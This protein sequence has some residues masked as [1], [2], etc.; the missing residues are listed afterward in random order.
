[1]KSFRFA[2]A[3]RGRLAAALVT[4]IM[5]PMAALA[6]TAA[7]APAA[8]APAATAPAAATAPG[9][10]TAWVKICNVDA[11]KNQICNI[12]QVLLSK[13]GSVIASFSIQPG[14]NKKYAA[15]AFVPLGFII[16]AGV[17]LTIDGDKKAV[18][19]FTICVPPTEG[20]P[21]GCAA[22]AD[23]GDDF[24]QAMRKGN[25]LG[26]V[27]ANTA[28]QPIPIEMTLIGFAGAYDGEGLDPA[29]ARAREV[30]QSKAL[31]EEA[32]AAFQRMIEKQRQENGTNPPAP[33]N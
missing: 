23:L 33:A 4:T 17:T 9:P 2:R 24:I 13:N 32:R 8:T 27:L 10:D 6:Q 11:N 28:G 29:Q 12:S 21:A 15:G 20:G 22:R 26:L 16:P 31:Q 1:M 5:L 3:T 19:Q 25:K 7:P 18:A 30:E 14:A